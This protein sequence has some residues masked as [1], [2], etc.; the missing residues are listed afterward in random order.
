MLAVTTGMRQGEILAL[1]WEDVDLEAGKVSVRRTLTRESGHYRLGEPKT[2]RSRRMIKLTKVATEALQGHLGRQMEEM[3][4]LGGLY[5]DQG[6]VFTTDS[7]APLNPSNIRNRN[8]RRLAEKANLPR[9]RFHDLRHCWTSS[10][11]CWSA[12]RTATKR[13]CPGFGRFWRRSPRWQGSSRTPRFG[14]SV[15]CS[16]PTP[17]G[18]SW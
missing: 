17:A 9:I 15:R 5:R 18:T 11:A 8:L 12:S 2:K 1:K 10:R 13:R 4:R 7:G 14:W 3:D 16:P 6:L